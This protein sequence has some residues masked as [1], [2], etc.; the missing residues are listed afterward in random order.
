MKD[1]LLER[2]LVWESPVQKLRVE[3]EVRRLVSFK[4]PHLA[5][6]EFTL[7]PHFNGRIQL[8]SILNG[9]VENVSATS[10]PRIGSHLEGNA[11]IMLEAPLLMPEGGLLQQETKE[12]GLMLVSGML[13][14]L[15]TETAVC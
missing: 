9:N 1:G 6:I 14:V 2:R 4:R 5:A 13:N 12:S 11:L 3:L 8:I 10:D 15:R 7:V